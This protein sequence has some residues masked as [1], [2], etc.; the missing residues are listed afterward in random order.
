M[1]T[2]HHKNPVDQ[3]EVEEEKHQYLFKEKEFLMKREYIYIHIQ[4]IKF[5]SGNFNKFDNR[6]EVQYNVQRDIVPTAP[7]RNLSIT[8]SIFSFYIT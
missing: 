6:R 4:L 1:I 5:Q 7:R 8:A 3:I 2:L